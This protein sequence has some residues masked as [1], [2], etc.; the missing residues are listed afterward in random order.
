[1]LVASPD[2]AALAIAVALVSTSFKAS[3]SDNTP[4]IEAAATSP[5]ECPATPDTLA[6]S[7]NAAVAR[8][9]ATI[10]G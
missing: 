5:T 8:L 4:A 1:M 3:V 6:L 7:S 2:A 10:S 9:A